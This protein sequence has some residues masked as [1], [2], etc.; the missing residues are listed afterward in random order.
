M[1]TTPDPMALW[2]WPFRL[3][4]GLMGGGGPSARAEWTTP[5]E[6]AADFT[7]MRLRAFVKDGAA[8]VIVV[9]PFAVHDAGIADLAP[10]HSLVER[11]VAEGFGPV[12][13]TEWKSATSGMRE[14]SIDAYLADLNAAVD[15]T[16]RPPILVGLCQGGWLSLLLAAAFPRKIARLVVAGAPVDVS[17]PSQIADSA[18]KIAPQLVEDMIAAG[19]GL[20][21]GRA[22]LGSFRALGHAETDVCGILQIAPQQDGPKPDDPAARFAAWD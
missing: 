17:H 18:R 12:L 7:T 14:L 5:N 8:P 22:T 16:A 1:E 4:L 10:G 11:L 2:L 20:V 21:S 19:G 3:G 13:L 15:L 6:V 9:A